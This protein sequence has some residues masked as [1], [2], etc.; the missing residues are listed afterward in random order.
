MLRKHIQDGTPHGQ[1]AR[2][3]MRSG[4]LLPDDIMLN[5]LRSELDMIR[6][7]VNNDNRGGKG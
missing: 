3:V 5:I 7:K 4:S 6:K 2:E 1:L